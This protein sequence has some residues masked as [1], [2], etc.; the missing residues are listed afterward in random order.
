MR[1]G[2]EVSFEAAEWYCLDRLDGGD[3]MVWQVQ[4]A[5]QRFSEVVR[6]AQAGEPQIVSRHGEEI[7]VIIDISEYRHLRGR[8]TPLRLPGEPRGHVRRRPDRSRLPRG[9][10]VHRR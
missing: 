9:R 7:V 2:R 3:A 6:A 10:A 8:S 1:S 5:K 4:E